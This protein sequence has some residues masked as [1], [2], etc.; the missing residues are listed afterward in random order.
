MP[1]I[2]VR[3]F[4][5]A[6]A[7]L[8]I[9][10]LFRSVQS[11]GTLDF[12]AHRYGPLPVALL[13]WLPRIIIYTLPF[14]AGIALALLPMQAG[15]FRHAAWLVGGVTGFLLFND[16]ALHRAWE[17]Y[18]RATIRPDS[19]VDPQ[20]HRFNDTMSVVGGTWAHLRGRVRPN[21]IQAWPPTSGG[22]AVTTTIEDD[23]HVVR[24]SAALFYERCSQFLFPFIGAG[25]VLGLGAWLRRA[26]TF[27]SL[28][29]ERIFRLV[30]AWILVPAVVMF[31][32]SIQNEILFSVSHPG[33]WIGWLVVPVMV[34]LI[35]A[36]V[37][38]R[39][40]HRLDGLVS[41]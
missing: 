33:Q 9:Y 27:R 39:A 11:Y 25:L 8:T 34:A 24:I 16:V 29:D 37:G 12:L 22:S 23:R 40:V 14:A 38:W 26:V 4:L 7:L 31:I 10:Q 20:L 6:V 3:Q 18:D 13:T 2:V 35:P 15:A 32:S 19:I 41:A 36:W 21:D 1:R 5:L 30:S 28:R 17:A